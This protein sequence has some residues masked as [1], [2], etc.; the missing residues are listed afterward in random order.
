[1]EYGNSLNSYSDQAFVVRLPVSAWLEKSL[2]RILMKYKNTSGLSHHNLP[3][4][5]N[6]GL[7][8][9][10]DHINSASQTGNIH[11]LDVVISR[12]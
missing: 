1:M 5:Q 4:T 10:L 12:G 6:R 3:S 8:N 9:N 2:I 11:I 7:L